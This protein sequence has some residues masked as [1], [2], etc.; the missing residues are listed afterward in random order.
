LD[1]NKKKA[2]NVLKMGKGGKLHLL[3]RERF[4]PENTGMMFFR[5]KI[6]FLWDCSFM[7]SD[8]SFVLC[9]LI[10]GEIADELNDEK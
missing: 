6:G 3:F 8:T 10:S 2:I 5:T 4:W 7:R 1:E 9:C